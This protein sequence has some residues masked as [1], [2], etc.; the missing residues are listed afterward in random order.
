MADEVEEA[1]ERSEFLLAKDINAI[2]AQAAAIPKGE[3][4][5]CEGCGETFARLVNGSCAPC[6]DKRERLY[7]KGYHERRAL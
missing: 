4:G 2:C 6:R 1:F 7:R 5:E 3:P